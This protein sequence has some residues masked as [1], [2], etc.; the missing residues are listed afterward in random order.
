MSKFA[1]TMRA[2]LVLAV[3]L[4]ALAVSQPVY[5]HNSTGALIGGL[6]AGALIGSVA[7][8][9]TQPPRTYYYAPPP[10]PAYYVPARPVPAYGPGYCGAPPYPPCRTPVY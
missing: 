9:A 8:A 10:P 5:A 6:V 3:V 2:G 4:P 1:T 7:T